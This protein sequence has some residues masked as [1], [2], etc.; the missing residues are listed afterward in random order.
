MPGEQIARVF[1][2]KAALDARLE[3]VAKYGHGTYAE[4]ADQG[5]QHAD[6]AYVQDGQYQPDENASHD[7]APESLDALVG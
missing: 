6:A 3:E 4:A 5:V 2:A 7:A 1:D